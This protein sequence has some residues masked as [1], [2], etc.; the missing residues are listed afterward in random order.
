M[1][2]R[3]RVFLFT[4]Y[5]ESVQEV[6]S[7]TVCLDME[8]LAGGSNEVKES[9]RKDLKQ[10]YSCVCVQIRR[11]IIFSQK[12]FPLQQVTIEAEVVRGENE[13]EETKVTFLNMFL[14]F[15]TSG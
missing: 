6:A 7:H 12:Q 14:F 4:K 11:K 1:P 5:N 10:F 9:K 2:P 13:D 8:E 15:Y 3:A